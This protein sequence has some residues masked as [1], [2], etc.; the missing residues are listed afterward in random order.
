MPRPEG[1][2]LILGSIGSGAGA[3]GLSFGA[4]LIDGS[5]GSGLIEGSSGAGAIGI[6][7]SSGAGTI[8]GTGS[9]RTGVFPP[10]VSLFCTFNLC[11]YFSTICTFTGKFELP[12]AKYSVSNV[13]VFPSVEIAPSGN[14]TS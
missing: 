1:A 4:G 13:M 8:G 5:F 12:F 10:C 9:G 3:I 7:G 6:S 2:G 11:A 14:G